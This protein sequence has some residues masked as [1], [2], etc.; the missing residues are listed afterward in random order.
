MAKAKKKTL[1]KNFEEL[2]KEG[3]L[4]KL[5]EVFESC[6]LN[7]CGGYSK[8][9]ALAF[10]ACP[11]E[12]ASWLVAQGADLSATD[13][14]GRT[15]LLARARSWRGNIQSLLDLGADVNSTGTGS[16]TP[17][18]ATADSVNVPNARLLI[19]KGAAV[20][21]LWKGM[22][23]LEW[24]LYQ[25]SNSRLEGMASF[26]EC[27]L[28]AGASRT[29]AMQGLVEKLGKTFEFHREGYNPEGRDAASAA[30]DRIYRMFDVVPVLRRAVHDGVA[31][32]RVLGDSLNEQHQAL[33]QL[34]VPSSGAAATVQGE[35]VRITG[36]IAIELDENG[37]INWD[38]DYRKMADALLDH[39]R[40]GNALSAPNLE[41]AASLVAQLKKKAG[42]PSRMVELG[43]AWVALNPAPI[44]LDPPDYA[45]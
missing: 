27:L 10:D 15:P 6:D 40:N 34:L 20:D 23:P 41:E 33:W 29:P 22:T 26:A 28:A 30:L 43:V 42:D 16:E 18:H 11:N 3:D 19:E 38:A 14:Y 44:K 37:G 21:A 36:R 45:R 5:K 9:T 4:A 39:L 13:S 32:I 31:P 35:V 12:L 8:Q 2:L 24:A 17:L 25:C 1:P 7:A